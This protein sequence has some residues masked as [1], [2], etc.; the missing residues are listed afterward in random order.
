MKSICVHSRIATFATAIVL[1]LNVPPA[2]AA[3]QSEKAGPN[4]R[5]AVE[6]AFTKWVVDNSAL[7]IQW[8]ATSEAMPAIAT[9]P[10]TCSSS[11]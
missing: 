10:G 5:G 7:P 1:L 11:T 6:I 2:L 4:D 8:W 9:L 3:D